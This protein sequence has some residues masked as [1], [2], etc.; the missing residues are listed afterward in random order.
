MAKI[1]NVEF[2]VL[3]E[4]RPHEN[5]VTSHPVEKG[6]DITDHIQKQPMTYSVEGF[7]GDS[8]SPEEKHLALKYL[9]ARGDVVKYSGRG[10][11]PKCVVE[12][13]TSNVDESSKKGF[14]FSLTLR[15]IRVANPSTVSTLPVNLK[16]DADDVGS[17]GRV[18]VK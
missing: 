14:D 15:E 1:D 17:A 2:N 5:E 10:V 16:V 13:F 7:V 4:S 9:W 8:E 12:N 11:L 6:V 18:Q 3:S